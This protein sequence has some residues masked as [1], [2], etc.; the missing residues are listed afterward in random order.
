[1]GKVCLMSY[2]ERERSEKVRPFL[3]NPSI[4]NSLHR[5]YDII[6]DILPKVHL[7]RLFSII[8]INAT[9]LLLR[10]WHGKFP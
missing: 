10:T 9:G 4:P 8:L 7:V 2:K 6:D 5:I 3:Y 1:M